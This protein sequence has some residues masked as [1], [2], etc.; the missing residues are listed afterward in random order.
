MLRKVGRGCSEGVATISIVEAKTQGSSDFAEQIFKINLRSATENCCIRGVVIQNN[1]A[2]SSLLCCEFR[3]ELDF[4]VAFSAAPVGIKIEIVRFQIV[5]VLVNEPFQ[6]VGFDVLA[7]EAVEFFC[8][9]RVGTLIR[10]SLF[11]EFNEIYNDL[12][13]KNFGIFNAVTDQIP[14]AGGV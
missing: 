8:E 2:I 12:R 3:L 9:Q 7:A 14:C 6:M 4:D 11:H 10:T 13:Q 5:F 1:T